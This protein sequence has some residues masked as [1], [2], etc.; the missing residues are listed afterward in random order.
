MYRVFVLKATSRAE[1]AVKSVRPDLFLTGYPKSHPDVGS[2]FP[3]HA[4]TTIFFTEMLVY[5]GCTP[6]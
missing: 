1:S 5:I 6:N 3:S 2:L 4:R